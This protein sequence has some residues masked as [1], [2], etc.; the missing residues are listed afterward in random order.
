MLT[1][2][3]L[4]ILD[5]DD[6]IFDAFRKIGELPDIFTRRGLELAGDICDDCGNYI[7]PV[8]VPRDGGTIKQGECQCVIEKRR[9]AEQEAEMR[10]KRTYLEK[11]VRECGIPP[12]L[13]EA[14]FENFRVREWNKRMVEAAK[15]YIRIWPEPITDGF[16]MGLTFTGSTGIGKSHIASVIAKEIIL[17]GYEDVTYVSV[18]Q[19]LNE[20]KETFDDQPQYGVRKKMADIMNKVCKTRLLVFDDLMANSRTEW[21]INII[22]D[23]YEHRTSTGL[24]TITTSNYSEEQLRTMLAERGELRLFSRITDYSAVINLGNDLLNERTINKAAALDKFMKN[25]GK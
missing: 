4:E 17:L 12:R 15:E 8:F 16:G 11:K 20:I 18:E 9:K 7:R 3:A 1:P 21:A 23:V 22:W 10:R 5:K 2:D 14:S 24:P 6:F 19:F 25:I 13:Q